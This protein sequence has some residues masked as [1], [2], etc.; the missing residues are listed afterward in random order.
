MEEG[1]LVTES[2]VSGAKWRRNRSKLGGGEHLVSPDGLG[3]VY[4]KGARCSG[5]RILSLSY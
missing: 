5:C 4:I 2:L 1:F 3:N